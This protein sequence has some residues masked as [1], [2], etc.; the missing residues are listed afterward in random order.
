MDDVEIPKVALAL[1]QN[2]NALATA[3]RRGDVVR[4]RRGAYCAPGD[5][6]ADGAARGAR[7]DRNR[8]LARLRAL[9][10]QLRVEHVFSH[11]SAALLHGCR[12]WRNPRETHVYQR[13]RASGHAAADV[14][15]HSWTLAPDDVADAAGLPVTTLERTV[16]DCAR[17]MHPLEGL[18]IA[19]S[20]LA[21]GVEREVLL[22]ALDE[23]GRRGVLR[24]RLVIELADAGAQ[25]AWETWVRYELLRAGLPRP[26]TQLPVETDRGLF[27][28]DL[29]YE[30]WALGIE[31]DGQ[32]KYRPNG[33]RPG[34]D[35]AQEYLHEKARAA[36]IRRAGVT[37]EHVTAA[38]KRDVPALIARLTSHLPQ[39]LVRAARP[40]PALPPS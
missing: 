19:D 3:A 38:D 8:A 31:F 36:A 6:R 25:S 27:H 30:Q 32:V 22:G 35:P 39:A 17:T 34:H 26:T 37:I 15:R 9:H 14:S 40:D 4:I 5:L 28:T 29:G 12:V 16:V 24:A 11:A 2:R 18:V 13:Y 33:V 21:Q 7:E 23:A 1:E 20:A 10:S